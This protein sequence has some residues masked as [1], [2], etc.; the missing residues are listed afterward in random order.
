MMIA[1]TEF[2]LQ[3]FS[4]IWPELE[5][6]LGLT[7]SSPEA[8]RRALRQCENGTAVCLRSPD[9]IVVLA[10]EQA[11]ERIRVVVLLAISTG[12]DGAFKRREPEVLAIAKELGGT[13]VVFETDRKG[14]RKLLG[15]EWF[16]EEGG[17]FVRRV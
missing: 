16:M 2:V 8:I 9:G 11:G 10:I 4:A 17:A 5:P 1:G 6:Y 3:D 14:W 15:A 7:N 12:V 13:E